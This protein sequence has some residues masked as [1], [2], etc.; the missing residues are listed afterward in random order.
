MKFGV[1]S[2]IAPLKKVAVMKPGK[3]LINADPQI[4]HYSKKFNPDKVS[5]NHEE[6][7]KLLKDFGTEVYFLSEDDKGIA[8]SVFTYDASLMTPLGAIIMSPGKKLRSGEEK[9]HRKFYESN[10]IPI[11]GSIEG[12]GKAEA[13]DTLW[14]DE[15][16]LIVGRGFRTNE[17]GANQLIRI[18]NSLGIKVH[19]VDLP[20]FYGQEAC[21]HLMSLISIVDEKKAIVY[22]PLLPVALL[23]LLINKGFSLIEAPKDE[24]FSSNTLNINVLAMSPGNCIM[25]SNLPE[26]QSALLKSGIRVKVFKG[27]ELCIGCEGG[28]TC[29]TRPLLRQ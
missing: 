25:L 27:D 23:E 17:D 12:S 13:G 14:L 22:M 9:I 24:F 18:F 28:P 1:S 4:W 6:F 3:A 26:T 21:L 11:I 5:E 16:T 29:L 8:D 2:M 7:I 19:K 15:K 20:V 10:K